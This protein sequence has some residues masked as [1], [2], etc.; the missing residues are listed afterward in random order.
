[1]SKRAIIDVDRLQ[2]EHAG[3]KTIFFIIDDYTQCSVTCL[4][5]KKARKVAKAILKATEDK[6]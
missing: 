2:V 6:K 4:S 5:R 3:E 1:M